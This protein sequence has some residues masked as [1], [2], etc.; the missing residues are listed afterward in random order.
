MRDRP[1]CEGTTTAGTPC[2]SFTAGGRWCFPHDPAN[3]ERMRDARTRGASRGG[4]LKAIHGRR[5]RLDDAAGL[6]RFNAEL[7]NRLLAGEL[8]VD[9]VRCV[10]YAL[11]L[12]KSLVEASNLEKRLAALEANLNASEAQGA[13]RW[14][15]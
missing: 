9:V 6:L 12:Q 8:E 10:V 5:P 15:A 11:S 1:T 2:R 4:K 13:Q 14:H 7:I 3:A